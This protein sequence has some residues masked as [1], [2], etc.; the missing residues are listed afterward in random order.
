VEEVQH[1]FPGVSD[2][3]LPRSPSPVGR[4]AVVN[5]VPS[6]NG[7][8]AVTV[9]AD[10][11]TAVPADS[12]AGEPELAV[13]RRYWRIPIYVAP[14]GGA[15]VAQALPAP[16]PAARQVRP[17]DLAYAVEVPS[18]GPLSTTVQGFLGALVTGRA[19][20]AGRYAAPGLMVDAIQP[21]VAASVRLVE[22]S[23]RREDR[24]ISDEDSTGLLPAGVAVRLRALVELV[25]DGQGQA[26]SGEYFLT[27]ATRDGRWEIT[28]LDD[29]PQLAGETTPA[30]TSSPSQNPSPASGTAP[31][32]SVASTPSTT[33]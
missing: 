11:Q 21:P 15:A 17:Q 19:E 26:R 24:A 1:L 23:V 31:G 30:V 14:D 6:A 7:V 10:V 33:N 2:L 5:A 27:A 28:G 18:N 32:A 3:R 9:S 12:A 16:V 8:W 4:V 25:D 29:V 20:E 22:V 13:A